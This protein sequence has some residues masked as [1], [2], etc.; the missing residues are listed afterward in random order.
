MTQQSDLLQQSSHFAFGKNWESYAE[1]ISD[2]QIDEATEGLK[3]LV[4]DNLNGLRVLDIGCGSGLHALCALRLGAAEVVAMDIDPDS[5]RTAQRVLSQ[6]VPE[7]KWRVIEKS[8]FDVTRNELGQFDLVYSW[9]V[10]HHTGDMQRAIRCAADLVRPG[11]RLV[12]ALYRKTRLCSF[13]K[14]EKKW[15]AA[16]GERAQRAA[17]AV[18]VW[19]FKINLWRRGNEFGSFRNFTANYKNNNRGMDFFHDVHDWMGGWPY[20]STSPADVDA[21]LTPLGFK[22][23]YSNAQKHVSWGAFGSGCDEF[24]YVR[25]SKG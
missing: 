14:I 16:A 12:I 20:E 7:L 3:R 25:E 15:Y 8:V 19:L 2:P 23:Q 11:G 13:W 6:R 4:G 5:V 18:Y 9:G 24:T 1:L 17:R 22:L 21:M 10:L